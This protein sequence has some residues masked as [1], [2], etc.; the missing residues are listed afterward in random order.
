[1]SSKHDIDAMENSPGPTTVGSKRAASPAIA[2]DDKVGKRP[3]VMSVIAKALQ[4]V[5]DTPAKT[6][7]LKFFKRSTS[8]QEYLD[9]V[10]DA[11]EASRQHLEEMEVTETVRKERKTEE[12]QKKERDAA[13][14]RKQNQRKRKHVKEIE[15]GLRSPGGTKKQVSYGCMT[16]C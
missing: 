6:G 11:T 5:K 12:R 16:L 3:K 14:L 9:Q 13:R 15:D 10:K 2:D 4:T 7:M 8:R 1:M